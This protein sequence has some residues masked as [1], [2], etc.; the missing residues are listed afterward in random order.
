MEVAQREQECWGK[1]GARYAVV[2]VEDSTVECQHSQPE[3]G[4]RLPV[5]IEAA[6]GI[7]VVMA[8]AAHTAVLES[9]F[10]SLLDVRSYLSGVVVSVQGLAW[11]ASGRVVV[12]LPV[13]EGAQ[14]S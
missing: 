11:K 10:A 1:E 3:M 6:E 13:E 2:A 14:S 8:A 12:A 4:S 5:G 9:E 7:E